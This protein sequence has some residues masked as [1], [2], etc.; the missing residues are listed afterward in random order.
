MNNFPLHRFPEHAP[1]LPGL[2]HANGHVPDDCIS[3]MKVR[4]VAHSDLHKFVEAIGNERVYF[5]T[6]GSLNDPLSYRPLGE[7]LDEFHKLKG[8]RITVRDYQDFVQQAFTPVCIM[9]DWESALGDAIKKLPD[10][11]WHV[12]FER[13]CFEFDTLN[14]TPG[15]VNERTRAL[16]FFH[17]IADDPT[18]FNV[19]WAEKIHDT[20]LAEVLGVW[21]SND[22]SKYIDA[23]A[24]CPTYTHGRCKAVCL[25]FIRAACIAIDA[26][27]TETEDV[28]PPA[29]LQK[30]R[31]ARGKA[32]LPTI[33]IINLSRRY[34]DRASDVSNNDATGR[35]VRLHLRRGHWWPRLDN[36]ECRMAKF[37]KWRPWT[38]VGDPDLG[39]IEH[40]YRI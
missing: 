3:D 7:R 21:T 5:F 26:G 19:L 37:R 13:A 31:K 2:P 24:K 36:E 35:R 16:F 4:G 40:H 29:K 22:I 23:W 1:G 33:R 14:K 12:P 38:M 25:S 17:A 6:G 9:H 8:E 20:Y 15:G 27:L 30:A 34:R 11:E 32:P 10:D 18:K 28:V 39:Y